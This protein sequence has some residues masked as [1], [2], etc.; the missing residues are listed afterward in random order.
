LQ[1]KVAQNYKKFSKPPNNAQIISSIHHKNTYLM[2]VWLTFC[3]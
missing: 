2:V 1:E 3:H